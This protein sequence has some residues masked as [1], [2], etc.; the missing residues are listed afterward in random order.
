LPATTDWRD[1]GESKGVVSKF[2]QIRN[3]EYQKPIRRYLRRNLTPSERILWYRLNRNQLGVRFF[4]QY[5]IGKY[6]VD[7]CCPTQKLIVEVDGDVHGFAEQ[8]RKDK[9]RTIWF[10]NLGY[11]VMRFLND[12]I[13]QDVYGVV[14]HILRNLK[15]PLTP[16]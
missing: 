12:D 16:P 8:E 6:V 1:K 14:D 11:R 9:S 5:G 2:M 15:P 10:Q 13:R 3:L 4:R 7:F